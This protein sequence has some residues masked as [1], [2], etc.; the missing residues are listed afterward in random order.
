MA[1][2]I[3]SRALELASCG[4]PDSGVRLLQPL[5]AQ[6]RSRVSALAAMAFCM[7]AKGDLAAARHLMAEAIRLDPRNDEWPTQLKDCEE[8]YQRR[9]QALLSQKPQLWPVHAGLWLLLAAAL[10]FG[11]ALPNLLSDFIFDLT[12]YRPVDHMAGLIAAAGLFLAG[13]LA[14]LHLGLARRHA[15]VRRLEAVVGEDYSAPGH[16]KCPLCHLSISDGAPR[17]PFCGES[18]QVPHLLRLRRALSSALPLSPALSLGVNLAGLI[19]IFGLIYLLSGPVHLTHP[20][21]GVAPGQAPAKPPGSMADLVAATEGSVALI[22]HDLG[23]GSGFMI[24]KNILATN[25]HVLGSAFP[26]DIKVCFPSVGGGSVGVDHVLYADETMDVALLKITT[27]QPP[28][29]LGHWSATRRGDDVLIIGNPGLTGE[30]IL[31]NTITR[32]NLNAETEI[33]GKSFIQISAP[34]NEGNS[35]GPALNMR[36]EVVAMMTLKATR[37]QGIAF[38]VSIDRITPIARQVRDLKEEECARR[39]DLFVAQTL[40]RRLSSYAN[41]NLLLMNA[42]AQGQRE[43]AKGNPKPG[44]SLDPV[45]ERLDEN[46]AKLSNSLP[47]QKIERNIKRIQTSKYLDEATREGLVSLWVCTRQMREQVESPRGDLAAYTEKL[48]SLKEQYDD[49]SR[50]LSARLGVRERK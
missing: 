23:S 33:N 50:L 47:A 39:T 3:V 26:E 45:G 48:N 49:L 18:R 40:Y 34:V 46:I 44:G 37:Q 35:G 22:R 31:K 24:E 14:L 20:P 2:E 6:E 27:D 16:V 12:A 38:G 13:G 17:C 15:F 1:Q 9:V 4:L 19:A 21:A 5:L 28:L 11:A 43:A 36:G 30:L 8:L 32:G 42:Y 7:Q 25:N 29:P 10:F 41:V